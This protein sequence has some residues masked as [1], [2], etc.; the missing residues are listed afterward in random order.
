MYKEGLEKT[1]PE[2][3]CNSEIVWIY[4]K[5]WY[6]S[7]FLATPEQI[8]IGNSIIIDNTFISVQALDEQYFIEQGRSYCYSHFADK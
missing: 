6:R 5:H 8:I 4:E 2:L 3:T 1:T 7:V